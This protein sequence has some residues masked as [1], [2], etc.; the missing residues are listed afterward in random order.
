MPP[1]LY[2][3]SIAPEGTGPG[4][5]RLHGAGVNSLEARVGKRL[6]SLAGLVTAREHRQQYHW[7]MSERGA[8][9]AGLEPATID[10]VRHGGPII[11]LGDR[12]AAIVQFGRELFGKHTVS[13]ETYARAL[14]TF[15]ETDLVDLVDVM[16][17]HASDATLLT[18]FDQHLSAGQAPSLPGR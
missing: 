5:I 10:L 15:G 4:Q 18:V 12:E 16:A 1:P 8:L 11:G 14:K 3:R 6:I 7:A 2:S 13:A 17:Q 9:D